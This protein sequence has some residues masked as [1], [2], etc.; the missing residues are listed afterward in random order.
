MNFF[1]KT[2]TWAVGLI[3]SIFAVYGTIACFAHAAHSAPAPEACQDQ[4]YNH[5][6]P[7]TT[8]TNGAKLYPL[9][10]TQ[11][12]VLDSSITKTPLWSGEHLTADRIKAAKEI[13]RKDEFHPE[14]N[15]SF[16]DRATL[17]DYLG[18]GFDRGH[19]SPDKDMPDALSMHE[20]FSLANMVPQNSCNNEI[21]WAAIEGSVRK[22]V[23]ENNEVYV[24]TG[25]IFGS[26]PPT[27]TIG[28][29]KVWVPTKIF[30]AIYDPAKNSEIIVVTDNANVQTYDTIIPVQLQEMT[31]INV[32]PTVQNPTVLTFPP[33]HKLSGS[34]KKGE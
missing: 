15:I 4:F 33:L 23:L 11:F 18:S 6:T 30:K 24:I 31:G 9:C 25:P 20:S 8:S 22:Y 17:A 7:D 5:Q 2:P 14:P 28:G 1:R 27:A 19:M 32:F 29:S 34:C 13:K 21:I 12:G 26:N 16:V 3:L 10:F